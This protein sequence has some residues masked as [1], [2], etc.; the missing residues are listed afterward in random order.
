MW[1][2]KH[3]FEIDGWELT[4]RNR[5]VSFQ[6]SWDVTSIDNCSNPQPSFRVPVVPRGAFLWPYTHGH[7]GMSGLWYHAVVLAA[8]SYSS[9]FYLPPHE[10]LPF[11]DEQDQGKAVPSR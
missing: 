2:L 9:S 7:V 1:E 3:V 6:V 10:H 4:T 11:R 5:A 8:G